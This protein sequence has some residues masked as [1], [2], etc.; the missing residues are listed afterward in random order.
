MIVI[1]M[2]STPSEKASSR[3]VFT[4]GL[5]PGSGDEPTPHRCDA[6]GADTGPNGWA[7]IQGQAY[8]LTGSRR[9]LGVGSIAAELQPRVAGGD[10]FQITYE[11]RV[12][13]KDSGDV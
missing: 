10:G 6:L 5:S 3:E 7:K 8:L 11:D 4:L 13:R 12:F 9:Q 2:A 1:T